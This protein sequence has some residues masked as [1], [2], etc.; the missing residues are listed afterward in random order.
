MLTKIDDQKGFVY[1]G[2]VGRVQKVFQ[3]VSEGKTITVAFIGGSITQGC[4][5]TEPEKCYAALVRDWFVREFKGCQIH[6]VNAG[7]GGTTSQYG[8]ARVQEDVLSGQ[9]DLVFVE[10]SVN[11]EVHSP[12]DEALFLETYEGLIRQILKAPSQP[13]VVLIHNFYYGKGISTEDLHRR[14]GTHYVLPSISMRETL[15]EVVRSGE[16]TV[17]DITTDGLH[18]NNAGH[19]M[20]AEQIVNA[21]V[22]MRGME[23][24]AEGSLPAPI[25]PNTYECCKRFQNDTIEPALQGFT[26]DLRP[27]ENYLDIFSKGWEGRKV[28]DTISFACYG[29]GIG[30]QYRKTPKK[31][32]PVAKVIL[33]GKEESAVIL[34]A[35]FDEDWGDSLEL[36]TI[37]FHGEEREHTVTV[38][39]TDATEQD[40]SSFY[41]VAVLLN[42]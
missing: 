33:D 8:A 20:I 30:L 27:K 29:S 12:A 13:A 10:F 28:G 19:A 6:Y 3:K 9:P 40:V 2:N 4:H 37:L 32:A 23:A 42:Q 35:N 26:K 15:C 24:Q 39:I 1:Q 7:I 14:I 5:A 22:A 25:T 18:P 16:L 31:P 41:L 17:E 21:L 38:T 36:E 11:D 34:D